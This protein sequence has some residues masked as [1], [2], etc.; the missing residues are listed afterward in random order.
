MRETGGDRKNKYS[1]TEGRLLPSFVMFMLPL[2][3]ASIMAQSYSIADGLILGNAVSEEALGAVNSVSVV[4][5]AC[6]LLQLALGNGCSILVSHLYGAGKYMEVD[7]LVSDIRRLT[8][9]MSVVIALAAFISAEPILNLLNTPE[10]LMEEAAAYMRITFIG[11]PFMALYSVQAGILRG[12][13]DSKR[14]L[15]GIA[16]SSGVNICLDLI[17]VVWLGTGVAGGAVA[18]VT[19][20]ALSAAYLYIRINDKRKHDAAFMA[21][22]SEESENKELTRAEANENIRESIRLGSPQILQSAA[23]AA[24]KVL[25]QNITNIMGA[26]VVIGVSVAFKV[27]SVMLVPL[28]GLATAVAVFTGQNTGA[29]KPERVKK[30]LIVG[31]QFAII[32]SV[33]MTVILWK[34]SYP[35]FAVFGLSE[36]AAAMGYRYLYVCLPFYWLFGMQFVLSGY[37]NGSKHTAITSVAAIAGLGGRLLFAYAGYDIIGTDALPLAESISWIIATVIEVAAIIYWHRK[38]RNTA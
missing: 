32:L 31:L 9:A 36:E 4:L 26:A 3:A 34:A 33:I 14:P 2:M 35:V 10:I 29:G 17:F 7:R 23:Q 12:M 30:T 37:L 18:T 5:D 38:D 19:A 24:G 25:L 13:G 21:G 6:I 16:V 20:E 11:V 15:G 8:T 1:V 28:M 22:L 27:D